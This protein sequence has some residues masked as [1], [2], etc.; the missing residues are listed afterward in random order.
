MWQRLLEADDRVVRGLRALELVDAV[1]DLQLVDALG[2]VEAAPAGTELRLR[3][4]VVQQV[5]PRTQLRAA[6]DPVIGLVIPAQAELAGQLVGEA[7][8]CGR[9]GAGARSLRP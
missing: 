3:R 1:L 2:L 7:P 8:A 6:V 5:C 9:E 4:I